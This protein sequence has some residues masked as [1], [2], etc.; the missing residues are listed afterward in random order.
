ME[1]TLPTLLGLGVCCVVPLLSFGAGFYLAKYGS[2]VQMA[3]RGF[4]QPLDEDEL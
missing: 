1:N 3:W 2:P 4:G